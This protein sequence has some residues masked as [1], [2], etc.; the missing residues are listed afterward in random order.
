MTTGAQGAEREAED[1]RPS[2][3]IRVMPAKGVLLAE[4]ADVVI[5][6]GGVIGTA[7]A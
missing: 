7:I 2:N 6:G 3:L 1:L 5:A 4:T